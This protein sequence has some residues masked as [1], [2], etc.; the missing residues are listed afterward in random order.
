VSGLDVDGGAFRDPTADGALFSAIAGNG[1]WSG[2]H[3]L[4][5]LPF[6]IN[7]PGFAEAAAA[8]FREIME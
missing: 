6:H 7:D 8:A 1:R 4:V 3:K 5:R 2:D